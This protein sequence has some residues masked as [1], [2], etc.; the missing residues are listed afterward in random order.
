[1]T[2]LPKAPVGLAL[3]SYMNI[4]DKTQRGEREP[5]YLNL[6]LMIHVIVIDES[7]RSNNKTKATST[8]QPTKLHATVNQKS[9]KHLEN[10]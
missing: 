9:K 10:I 5:Y 8:V 1:M 3:K 6:T 7:C 4:T 2:K